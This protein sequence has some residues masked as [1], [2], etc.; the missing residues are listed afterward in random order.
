MNTLL[1]VLFFIPH[2]IKLKN[3][4]PIWTP[5]FRRA[6]KEEELL[7]EEALKLA[8]QGVIERATTSEYNSPVMVVP[9]KDGTWRS[10]IDYRNINKET[11]KEN[12][13]ILRTDDAINAL[14]KAKYITKIDYTSGYWQ[15]KLDED[16]KRLTA[17]TT[18]D[19]RW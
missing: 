6:Y 7:N 18:K 1:E 13:P 12:W 16:S 19:G 15:I 10:V 3:S 9:K 4:D 5:Q 17:F 2:R 14:F 11:I 8:K